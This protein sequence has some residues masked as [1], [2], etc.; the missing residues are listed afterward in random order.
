MSK[1][2]SKKSL[3]RFFLVPLIILMVI[4]SSLILGIIEFRDVVGSIQR[5][6]VE[7]TGKT[8]ENRKARLETQMLQRWGMIYQSEEDLTQTLQDFLDEERITLEELN[9]SQELQQEYLL[10]AFP[11]CFQEAQS[12]ET[13]GFFFLM[14]AGDPAQ[15]QEVSGFYVRD[16]DPYSQ[17]ADNT[18][19]AFARSSTLLSRS[20]DI[21]LS[22]DWT[23]YFSMAGEGAREADA[24]YY[25]P[26][27]AA[28]ENPD[29]DTRNLGYWAEPFYL[30]GSAVSGYK[31]V[32]YSIPLRLNGQV[33]GIFGVEITL[34]TLIKQFVAS[35][36][37]HQTTTG[38]LIAVEEPDGSC[39]PI[40]GDGY[41]AN[42]L[43]N[44]PSFRLEDTKYDT[45]YQVADN[46]FNGKPLY[47]A[48]SS[49][50]L[51]SNNPPYENSNWVFLGLKSHEELFGMGQTL[52]VWIIAAVLVGLTFA[53]VAIY[54]LVRHLTDPIQLLT[55]SIGQGPRGLAKYK[56]S[57]IPEID[58]IYRVVR[59]LVE[60]Q[61]TA[62]QALQEEASR[63]RIA[64]ENSSSSF[65]TYDI[66]NHTVDVLN[67]PHLEGTWDCVGGEYG[68]FSESRIYPGDQAL[69]R[70]LFAGLNREPHQ[71]SLRAQFRLNKPGQEYRWKQ[72]SGQVLRSPDGTAVKVVCSLRDIDDEKRQ[73]ASLRER[74]ARDGVTGVYALD[75]GMRLLQEQ[76]STGE[77]GSLLVLNL[78]ELPQLQIKNG[79][80]FSQLLLRQLSPAL[81][82]LGVHVLRLNG[83]VFA[84]WLP[85]SSHTQVES[86]A[87]ELL[88]RVNTA[89]PQ[90]LIRLS[91]RVGIARWDGTVALRVCLYQA[92]TAQAFIADNPQRGFAFF[93]ELP[94]E[95]QANLVPITFRHHSSVNHIQESSLV[96]LAINLLGGEGDF[97]MKMHLLMRELS[98]RLGAAGAEVSLSRMD[99]MSTS[100]EYSYRPGTVAAPETTVQFFT[101]PQLDEVLSWTKNRTMCG[102]C[103][104]DARSILRPFLFR[105]D[106]PGIFLPLYDD[107]CY[108]GC[109]CVSG[110]AIARMDKAALEDLSQLAGVL[111]S[112]IRQRQHDAAARAK[113]DFLSRMSHEIRTPM[114]G[115]IGMTNIALTAGKTPEEMTHCLQKISVTSQYLLGL[116]NDIL[117]M[118]KIESGKMQLVSENFDL[119]QI[120]TT[121]REL[122]APQ[123]ESKHLEFVE[124]I[125]LQNHWFQGDSLRISQILVNI[126]GNA[127]KFT[128]AGG[129]VR[130][131][132]REEKVLDGDNGRYSRV[133]FAVQ[134]TGIGIS[135]E[136]QERIFRSFEQV[137]GVDSGGIRGTGLGLS[138]SSRLARLM[139]GKI[140]LTSAPGKGSTFDFT[141]SLLHGTPVTRDN[142]HLRTRFDG[143]RLLLVEDNSL[144]QEIAQTILSDMGFRVDTAEDGDEAVQTL[145]GS[146]PGA[147]DLVL[148][149]IMMPRM[150][151]LE[152][153]HLIRNTP[154]RPDLRVLPILAMSA[155]AFAEDVKKSL[156]AG[157]NGHLSKPIEIEKLLEALNRVLGGENPA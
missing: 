12:R 137:A 136:N 110:I 78:L 32:T 154:A 157:M 101:Q 94:A 56:N 14:T 106:Q 50:K 66:S 8:V 3:F 22:S 118:S 95:N 2:P 107:E 131:T 81:Q 67:V 142:A 65:Y 88:N 123:A 124:E 30:E 120:L 79:S 114:N 19:L 103:P 53:V 117:D 72:F 146:N 33:Y 5:T 37:T 130:L 89:F 73:E 36:A 47:A 140:N 97:R 24:F 6:S 48:L 43:L 127:V 7:N 52:Y 149:D 102:F 139:G 152:A 132:I 109:L 4:Q 83:T 40:A 63:Y 105:F 156:E 104:Q 151:G 55:S 116:L 80:L 57:D 145:R 27:R 74:N 87:R 121:V 108:M 11:I 134:D 1:N 42:L 90:N 70:E 129:T 71:D 143:K 31:A 99:S 34:P 39:R 46:E 59:Q 84:Y 93:A 49:L 25:A 45:L 133:F 28:R 122:I 85:D 126:L 100:L 82:P 144:N 138:I 16:S 92:N 15:A 75:E 76:L 10:R 58:G 135:K 96:Y 119:S 150:N 147:Y 69:V 128:P 21:A 54:V 20:L 113:S 51:Y 86:F 41:L 155:N 64:I 77:H 26:W 141:L 62:E 38:Y 23:T 91:P 35:E 61:Q 13:T 60:K 153:T 18:D 125:Q 17:G 112:Y 98:G 148:M 9:H 68:F 44:Q 111:Q 115:I 29:A